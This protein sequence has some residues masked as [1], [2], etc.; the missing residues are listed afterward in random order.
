MVVMD[1][2]YKDKKNFLHVLHYH[3]PTFFIIS[4]YF[5]Y[6]T[7]I[8]NNI[9]KI[10]SRLE[11]LYFPYFSWTIISWFVVNINLYIRK[12]KF[13]NKYRFY[14][15]NIL[16]GHN[17]VPNFWFQL[18]LIAINIIFLIVILIFGKNKYMFVLNNL[19]IFSYMLQYSGWNY[20][21]FNNHYSID[22]R[23]TYGRLIECIPNA[24]SGFYLSSL[25][26][27]EKMKNRRIEIIYFCL[28]FLVV[29]SLSDFD[30]L[31]S[32]KYGGFRLNIAGICIFITFL[33][34]PFEKINNYYFN[35][36]INYITKY[37]AGI[38]FMHVLFGRYA[39]KYLIPLIINKISGCIIIYILSYIICFIMSKLSRNTKFKHLFE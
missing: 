7:L 16:N 4:F 30:L 13:K 18:D 25:N 29:I 27:S 5:T 3:I 35:I 26:I 8:S 12:K 33:I 28:I 32:L 14:I 31:L 34:M 10:K 1:H 37:T 36:I 38:Y 11:R 6:K 19:F 39:L 21:F 17:I 2:F 23:S 24:I 15:N 9:S 20:N 22:Y